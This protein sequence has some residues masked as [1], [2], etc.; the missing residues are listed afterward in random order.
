VYESET[1]SL[2]LWEEYRPT[3]FENR[4]LWEISGPEGEEV[5]GDWRKFPNE[6]HYDL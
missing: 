5:T 2:T 6:D 3:V 1:S 4:V